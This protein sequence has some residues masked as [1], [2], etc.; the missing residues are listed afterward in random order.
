MLWGKTK[1]G[2]TELS[3]PRAAGRASPAVHCKAE[4]RLTA[5]QCPVRN[6]EH[7]LKKGRRL[8]I[9]WSGAHRKRDGQAIRTGRSSQRP[10]DAGA[11]DGPATVGNANMHS[12]TT[13]LK[14]RMI[15]A[16]HPFSAQRPLRPSRLPVFG[17]RQTSSGSSNNPAVVT[18]LEPL[19]SRS[20]LLHNSGGMPWHEGSGLTRPTRLGRPYER[21]TRSG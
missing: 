5:P 20:E 21:F 17:S 11:N 14:I 16:R 18:R 2:Q 7:T 4:R 19:L 10:A 13:R 8:V 3:C 1:D 9:P 12:K 6:P 15:R